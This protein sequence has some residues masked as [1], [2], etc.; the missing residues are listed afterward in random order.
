MWR[1]Q[2]IAPHGGASVRTAHREYAGEAT[3]MMI[4]AQTSHNFEATHQLLYTAEHHVARNL[5]EA[6]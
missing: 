1:S 6:E 5:E 4:A 2:R 3:G